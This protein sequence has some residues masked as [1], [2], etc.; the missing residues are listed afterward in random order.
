VKNPSCARP[1]SERAKASPSSVNFQVAAL[2]FPA[3][4]S[5]LQGFCHPET[6]SSISICRSDGECPGK[7]A[8]AVEGRGCDG[9]H[10]ARQQVR[11]QPYVQ[12]GCRSPKTRE[13][14]LPGRPALE[15]TRRER[16]GHLPHKLRSTS[17]R[18]TR[19]EAIARLGVQRHLDLAQYPARICCRTRGCGS[20]HSAPPSS[21]LWVTRMTPLMGHPALGPTNPGKSVRSVFPPVQHHPARKKRFVHEQDIRMNHEAARGEPHAFAAIAARPAHGD[22]R[23]RIRPSPMRS[24]G[25]QGPFADVRPRQSACA[26]RPERYVLEPRSAME[27]RAK[28]WKTMANPGR[29]ARNGAGPIIAARGTGRGRF[30]ASPAMSPQPTVDFPETGPPQQAD[31]FG[32]SRQLRDSLPSSNQQFPPPSRLWGRPCVH[33]CI[34]V[35]GESFHGPKPVQVSRYFTLG[36]SSTRGRQKKARLM[37]T[38]NKLIVPYFPRLDAMKV[39]GGPSPPADNTSRV[40]ARLHTGCRPHVANSAT[41]AAFP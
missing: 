28:L 33:R 10:Q 36:V 40:P 19:V 5:N 20:H 25:R 27:T 30:P 31:D 11:G 26:S 4:R 32:H 13:A 37:T 34:A 24:I 3:N 14:L 22:R 41:M 12:H 1:S 29:R 9:F 7:S 6:V 18:K 39:P 23:T 17:S 2:E 21:M 15:P 35:V 8:F 38:T 16:R